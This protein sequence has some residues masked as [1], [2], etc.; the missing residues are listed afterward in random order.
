MSN[1]WIN[2]RVLYWHIQCSRDCWL[3]IKENGWW[4][5]SRWQACFPPVAVYCLFGKHFDW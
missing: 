1:L 3:R 5:T 2:V 4:A